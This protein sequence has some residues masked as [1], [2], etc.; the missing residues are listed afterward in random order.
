M[1]LWIWKKLMKGANNMPINYVVGT[2]GPTIVIENTQ[3]L[4]DA[5]DN[6]QTQVIDNIGENSSLV[7]ILQKCMDEIRN[8]NEGDN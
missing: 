7:D 6:L 4:I 2:D 8:S 5:L 3:D 1:G